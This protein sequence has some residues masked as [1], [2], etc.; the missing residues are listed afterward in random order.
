MTKRLS[1]KYN[2]NREINDQRL[3]R[4][5]IILPVEDE[6]N[7]DYEYMEQYMI[8]IEIQF[9]EKYLNYIKNN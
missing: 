5:T 7:P 3:K 1:E 6:G 9:L 2:F 4:E 8:N